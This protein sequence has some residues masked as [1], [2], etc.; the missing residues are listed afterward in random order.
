MRNSFH[1]LKR[2]LSIIILSL[3]FIAILKPQHVLAQNDNK[4]NRIEGLVRDAHTQ[5]PINAVQIDVPGKASAVTDENG[6]FIIDLPVGDEVLHL[7][8]FDYEKVE[9]PVQGKTY[10]VIDLYP[11]GFKNYFKNILLPAGIVDN[12]SLTLSAKSKENIR[13]ITDITAGEIIQ[14]SLGGDV[15]SISQSGLIGMGNSMFIRGFN[16]LTVAQPLFV[17]DG[18]IWSHNDFQ[19]IHK[20]LSYNP[21]EDIDVNDIESITVLKD[22]TS[23]YGSRAANG[24]I[25]ITTKQ[26][27]S[28]VTKIGLNIFYG[29]TTPPKNTPMMSAEEY[30]TFA[31]DLI[32]SYQ[33]NSGKGINQSFLGSASI[34]KNKM[35]YNDTDWSDEVYQNGTVGNYVVNVDGGDDRAMYYF[36][37][38][39]SGVE[40]VVKETDM[41]RLNARF[42]VDARLAKI[43][44]TKANVAFS[45]VERSLMDDGIDFYSSPTWQ[46]QIKSPFLTPYIFNSS[47][48]KTHQLAFADDFGIANPTGIIEYSQNKQKK[49]RFNIGFLPELTILPE[50]KLSSQF[51]YS[52]YNSNEAYFLPVNYSPERLIENKGISENYLQNQVFKN[53][54]VFSDSRLAYNKLFKNSHSLNAIL[55]FRFEQS[56]YEMDYVEEHN[57]GTNNNTMIKGTYKFRAVAGANTTTKRMSNYLNLNYD[58]NKKYFVSA[59]ISMDA[60]SRFGKEAEDGIS[61]MGVPWGVFP[62][63]NGAWLFTSEKFMKAV[64]FINFGKIRAGYGLTGNDAIPD[65]ESMAYLTTVR[66]TG[67]ANGL[68]L[69]HYG[70]EEIQ[71]EQ[72]GRANAGIDLGLF[73]NRVNLSFDVFRS[74]T[75]NLLVLKQLPETIDK[76]YYWD[77]GGAMTNKGYELSFDWK[78]LNLKDFRWDLG[79]SI[80]HY[81]NEVTALDDPAGYFT[82]N[83]MGAEIITK[84]G[85][86]AGMFYGY[87]TNGIFTKQSDADAAGLKKELASGDFEYFGAGDVVFVDMDNNDI[88][89]DNDKQIIGN[90][91]PDFYGTI[92]TAWMFKQFKL[93]TLFTYS[94]GNDVY[95]YYRC[96]LETGGDFMNQSKAM[97]NRWIADGQETN[98]PKAVYGDPMGNARFSDRWIEDGSY[99]KLKNVTLSYQIPVKNEFIRGINVWTSVNNVFTLTKYLG[100]DPEFSINNSPLYQGVDAGFLP[101][102]RSYYVGVRVDL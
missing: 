66:F 72:T 14:T 13:Q 48:E 99:L 62:S 29:I 21:L 76:G 75:D 81:K 1:T 61:M 63:V 59:T 92:N 56:D 65:F 10:V 78:A 17:V 31:G 100:R 22:G 35:Y 37:I 39:Y 4:G 101:A 12:S 7:T 93:N 55:G 54:A 9:T 24:V 57:S 60:S 25:L 49:Y 40:G 98:Q 27:K 80:G 71:W 5:K 36:S 15:R 69:S 52:L 2:L 91:N 50:L 38:G 64:N 70:N 97:L 19:S 33:L 44:T 18:V 11:K 28:M 95:N 90:P 86:P 46:A 73:K 94:Y 3:S 34:P 41:Q 16:S 47:G 102:P 32:D 88:I 74:K 51:D 96:M 6:K 83:V 30:R 85:Q 45:R 87:K 53:N 84:V 82:T 77:N 68:V 20:G 67:R 43:L 58:Y 42:N 89:D 79:F 23:I 8:A 26:A